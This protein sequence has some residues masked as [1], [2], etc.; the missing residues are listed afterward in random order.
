[1]PDLL[2]R[3][4]SLVASLGGFL[5]ETKDHIAR[6]KSDGGIVPKPK[7]LDLF[8][9][10][11][12]DNGQL[13]NLFPSHFVPFG[14][15]L[16]GSL[17]DKIYDISSQQ[18]DLSQ[19]GSLRMSYDSS[20]WFGF[21]VAT[22]LSGG[23]YMDTPVYDTGIQ[24]PCRHFMGLHIPNTL[25]D[26]QIVRDGVNTNNRHAV[27]YRTAALGNRYAFFTSGSASPRTSSFEQIRNREHIAWTYQA[28]AGQTRFIRNSNT[29]GNESGTLSSNVVFNQK[30][31]FQHPTVDLS[32]R[33]YFLYDLTLNGDSS[34]TILSSVVQN[35][36]IEIFNR[37]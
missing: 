31:I 37:D 35:K 13:S 36:L 34:D 26:I 24:N 16:D 18:K 23:K 9:R 14:V 10:F 5:P 12:K 3:R 21:P 7:Q 6:V 4:R 19:T 25:S 22:A 20:Y 30:R 33:G 2:A 15:K 27:Q 28:S 8:Y 32:A 11:L 29:D 1:M 17:V